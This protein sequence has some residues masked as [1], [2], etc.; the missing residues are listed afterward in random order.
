[1]NNPAPFSRRLRKTPPSGAWRA[2]CPAPIPVSNEAAFAAM[3][4]AET[5]GF[6]GQFPMMART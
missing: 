4:A 5:V 6:P 1:M 3:A 2:F